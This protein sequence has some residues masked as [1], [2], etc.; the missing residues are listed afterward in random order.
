M[1]FTDASEAAGLDW[2]TIKAGVQSGAIPT[3]KFGKRQLIPREAF[4]R[5]I[6]GD[7]ASE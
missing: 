2:R 7:S 4:M 1:T 6:A 5:I 3:V